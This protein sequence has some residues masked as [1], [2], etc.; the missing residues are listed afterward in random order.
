MDSGE[1][2]AAGVNDEAAGRKGPRVTGTC[3]YKGDVPVRRGR[4]RMMGTCPCDGDVYDGDVLR[5]RGRARMTGTWYEKARAFRCPSL[6][7]TRGFHAEEAA[8]TCPFDGDVPVRRGRARTT[9]TYRYGGNVPVWRGRARTA[10]EQIRR[11]GPRFT[12]RRTR[13]E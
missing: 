8:G 5:A 11:R 12:Q 2:P 3:P 13:M 6:F 10:R 9:E 4:A 1:G 7:E